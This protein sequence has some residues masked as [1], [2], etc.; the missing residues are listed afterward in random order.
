M[1]N[2]L[3]NTDQCNSNYVLHSLLHINKLILRI[4]KRV[5]EMV[6]N[7]RAVTETHVQEVVLVCEVGGAMGGA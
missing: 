2:L 1:L 3:E 7:D 4:K 5:G 6:Y